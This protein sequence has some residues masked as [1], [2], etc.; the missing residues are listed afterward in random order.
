[1]PVFC[2]WWTHAWWLHPIF[3]IYGLPKIHKEGY[4]LRPIISSS[5]TY[6]YNLAKFLDSLIKPLLVSSKYILNDTF[7]FINKL[8][9]ISS[10]GL[11]MVSF[12]VESLFTNIPL[13]ETIHI[14]CEII[15]E[16]IKLFHGFTESQFRKMLKKATKESHFQFLGLVIDQIGGMAMGNPL[17]PTF[18]NFF[19]N[20]FE[21]KYMNE[22]KALGVV[23]WFRYVD[24]TFVLI[25]DL[26]V[27]DKLL[28]LMN[29]KHKNMHNISVILPVCMWDWEK[30]KDSFLGCPR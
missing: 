12:D 4:P 29:S 22:F 5:G 20:W 17:S 28:S 3:I 26:K 15:F 10:C 8:S 18:A 14:I 6:N 16:K 25:K 2:L 23:T 1:M 13:E 9:K 30:Q 21:C 19:M 7:D 11:Y 27:V 24:D